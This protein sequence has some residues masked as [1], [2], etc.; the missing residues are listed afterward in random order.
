MIIYERYI[1]QWDKA[2]DDG[3]TKVVVSVLDPE[4]DIFQFAALM[5]KYSKIVMVDHK[6]I[7]TDIMFDYTN[8]VEWNTIQDALDMIIKEEI[9][10][11]E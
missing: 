3:F 7:A 2:A 9:D 10:D 11:K 8:M 5:L 6:K 1:I 4:I